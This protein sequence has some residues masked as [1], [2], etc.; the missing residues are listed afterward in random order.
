MSQEEKFVPITHLLEQWRLGDD[1]ALEQLMPAVDAELH[2]LAAGFMRKERA[3]HTLAVGDL[4]N[5]A[6]IQLVDERERHFTNR[7][8]FFAVASLIMKHFLAQYARASKA[9]RRGGDFIRVTLGSD[10]QLAENHV[11][12]RIDCLM[13]AIERLA[14]INRRAARILELHYYTGLAVEEIAELL[15]LGSATVKRDLR[16]ARAWL[17]RQLHHGSLADETADADSSQVC[18]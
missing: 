8:H 9:L 13:D 4:V 3:G 16:F 11:V 10:D 18:S 1:G 17:K 15:S 14:A 6:F 12:Q 5:E 2:R 7:L